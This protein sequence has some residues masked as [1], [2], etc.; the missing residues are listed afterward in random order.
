MFVI[1]EAGINHNGNLNLACKL[2]DVAADAG[3]DA[4]K[5]QTFKASS[6]ISREAPLAEY[7]KEAVGLRDS[8]LDLVKA[9]ELPFDAFRQLRDYCKEKRIV[10]FSSP[11]DEA[12]VEYLGNLGVPLFKVPSGEITNLPLLETIAR[13]G[14]PMVVSTG[15]STLGEVA[16]ALET[17]QSAGDPEVVLLHCLSNYPADPAE[18]NLRAMRTM[19][20]RFGLPVGF[21]DHTPG[22]C[23]S[24]AAVAMGARV[25]EK[26][27]TLDKGLSG[28]DHNASLD[29][30]ELKELVRGVRIVECALGT[31]EKKPADS[32]R[33]TARV[34]RKS[35]VAACDIEIGTILD[36]DMILMK[37]PGTGLLPSQVESVLGRKARKK[38]L[39]DALFRL[40][41][42]A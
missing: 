34:A 11:F 32:E 23:V 5:F 20:D 26:H 41:M 14:L 6:V 24:L 4:V 13:W 8:Q 2:I 42:F 40:D 18:A 21:S 15:M 3:A 36:R 12:S 17:I 10:F 19:S 39:A 1:A 28:P 33:D 25:I 22:I 9:F 29:P 38:I 31:G 37:R 27:F 30:N 35:L 16:S 7:Q